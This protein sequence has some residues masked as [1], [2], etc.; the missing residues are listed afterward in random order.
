VIWALF[1]YRIREQLLNSSNLSFQ[2]LFEDFHMFKVC[3]LF[4]WNF[5]FHLLF[6]EFFFMFLYVFKMNY[7]IIFLLNGLL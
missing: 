5:E 2:L 1:I 7:F 4:L 3:L 6:N